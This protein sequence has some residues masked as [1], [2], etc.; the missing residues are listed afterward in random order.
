[1]VQESLTNVMRHAAATAVAIAI[2]VAGDQLVLAVEDNGRGIA[3]ERPVGGRFGIIGM[4][5]RTLALGGGFAVRA[6][7]HGG[8]V[9]EVVVPLRHQGQAEEG[10]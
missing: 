5:E 1:M 2:R 4:R 7:G 6:G 9:V 10:A 3:A 8:T